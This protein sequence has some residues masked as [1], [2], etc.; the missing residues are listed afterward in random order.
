MSTTINIVPIG[1]LVEEYGYSIQAWLRAAKSLGIEPHRIGRIPH[2][3]R[4]D[5][6]RVREHLDDRKRLT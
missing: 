4:D 5:V 2:L 3:D 6:D 1:E